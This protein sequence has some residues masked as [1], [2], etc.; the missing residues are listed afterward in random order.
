M[1][2]YAPA[3]PLS[4]GSSSLR[5]AP[6]V[7]FFRHQDGHKWKFESLKHREFFSPHADGS[8]SRSAP[9]RPSDSSMGQSTLT[10]L[11][12]IQRQQH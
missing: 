8:S 3:P 5:H 10:P 12:P 2:G 9:A 7:S 6:G 4:S 11:T 1:R